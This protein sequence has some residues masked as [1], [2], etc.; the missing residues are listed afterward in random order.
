MSI[1]VVFPIMSEDDP[2]AVG[3]VGTWFALDG[4]MVATGQLIAEV[5]VEKVSADV[6]APADGTLRH[7]V[8]EEEATNQGAVIARIE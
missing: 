5:Q 3:V 1:D 4:E 8:A 2:T 6:E 7:V